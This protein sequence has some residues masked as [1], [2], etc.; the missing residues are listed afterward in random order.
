MPDQVMVRGA[1]QVELLAQHLREVARHDLDAELRRNLSRVVKTLGPVV[2]A[3]IP[4]YMPGEYEKVLADAMRYTTSV[5]TAGARDVH[6]R[7]Y[8][9]AMGKAYPRHLGDIEQGRLKHPVFGRYRILKTRHHRDNKWVTQVIRPGFWSEP[10][11]GEQDRVQNGCLEAMDEI[12]EKM[13][14][15]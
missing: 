2:T 6:V 14:R 15:G 3:A 5:V 12:A 11:S 9:D 4:A 7:L 8:G 1:R 10:L 13:T